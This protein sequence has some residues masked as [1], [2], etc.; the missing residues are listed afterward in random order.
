MAEED[1]AE[2]EGPKKPKEEPKRPKEEPK[3][4][5]EEPQTNDANPTGPKKPKEEPDV[6]LAK[7]VDLANKLKVPQKAN[8][9]EEKPKVDL[10]KLKVD[11]LRMIKRMRAQGIEDVF[12]DS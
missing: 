7:L 8:D 5:K 11:T 2:R 12:E 6:D 1:D 3:K 9:N 4:P 10:A